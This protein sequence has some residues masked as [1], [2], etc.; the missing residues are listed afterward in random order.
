MAKNENEQRETNITLAYLQ[1]F[2]SV[3]QEIFICVSKRKLSDSDDL[4]LQQ[5]LKE[6]EHP[7][8][9]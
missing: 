5:Q 3:T 1:S 8:L 9:K 6:I 4:D 7:H 2:L